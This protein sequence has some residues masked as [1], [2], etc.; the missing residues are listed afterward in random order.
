MDIVLER[1]MG[2][3]LIACDGWQQG[4]RRLGMGHAS[5]WAPGAAVRAALTPHRSASCQMLTDCLPGLAAVQTQAALLP[6]A[7]LSHLQL[8]GK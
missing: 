1:K 5:H 4:N 7:L 2:P 8:I 3:P 6:H